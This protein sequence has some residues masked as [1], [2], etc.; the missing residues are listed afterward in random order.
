[1]KTNKV[2]IYRDGIAISLANRNVDLDY[3]T[4]TNYDRQVS[5]LLNGHID[6][7]WNGPL[8]HVR[9][10][11]RAH[12][13]RTLSLGMR[14][15]DRDFQSVIIGKKNKH[16]KHHSL[17]DLENKRIAAGTH[18]S[19][20]AYV[21]PFHFLK[22]AGVNLKSLDVTRFDRD[23]GK[24]G[25]T[26]VGEEEVLK[27]VFENEKEFDVGIVSQMMFDRFA[28][29]QDLQ[30]LHMLPTFDHCQ[31]DCLA[32]LPAATRNAFTQALFSM[33][34]STNDQ[35][36]NAMKLEGI[37]DRWEHPRE[38]GYDAVRAALSHEHLVD[39]PQPVHDDDAVGHPFKKLTIR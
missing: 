20:Q 25:D 13:G 19:P 33:N 32:S 14:D 9:L 4:F 38:S 18:D 12:K 17:K 6:I 5:A 29:K 34:N 2:Y 16:V 31:F 3:V 7:A 27:N 39:F 1:M 8:A 30:I 10:Q 21:M 11:K 37:R 26:A 28:H 35:D 23:V 22:A 15:V 24:H 36:R